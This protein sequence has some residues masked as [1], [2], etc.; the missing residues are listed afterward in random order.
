MA[1]RP[2]SRAAVG[3]LLPRLTDPADELCARFQQVTGAIMAKGVEDTAYYR[4]SRAI[5][6]NEVGG[7]PARFGAD[8][9]H[10]PRRPA[11]PAARVGAVDD[12]AVHA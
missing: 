1:R 11:A 7:D 3:A 12:D 5:W 2:G 6:L 9:R 10:V 8:L 4:Y